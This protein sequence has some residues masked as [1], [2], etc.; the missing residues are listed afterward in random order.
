MFWRI[1]QHNAPR[2]F[3]L[4]SRGGGGGGGGG[5]ARPPPPPPPR[6]LDA[7]TWRKDDPR[8]GGFSGLELSQ[9]GMQY[10]A[11]SD[12]GAFTQGRISRDAEGRIT[13][14]TTAPVQRL[15]GQDGE[16]L[17]TNRSDSE[18]LA[19]APDGSVY[20][21]F[22]GAARVLHYPRL[23]GSAVALP[24]SPRF[25]KL[26]P[27]SSLESLAIGPDG[28][29]YSLPERTGSA[30]NPFPVY[31]FKAGKW[32][33]KLSI[34]RRGGFLPVG[35]DFGPDGRFYLL[36]RDFR[37]LAGFASRLRRF[38]VT[39]RGMVNEVTLLET[40]LGLYDNLEGL[41][42]W[43]DRAGHITATMVSDDNFAFFLRTQLVEYRLPD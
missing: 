15:K 16:P 3:P 11:L 39:A 35:S 25:R 18:G 19:L 21:S 38:D 17:A 34:P 24:V 22:E 4:G 9:D 28:A 20:V 10:I 6:F 32:D 40:P 41:S 8:F 23:G 37:G 5:G 27:N 33:E 1:C 30:D 36:E 14:V 26:Q 42:I 2:F 13:A 29:L 12:R 31:R 7:F 43:R